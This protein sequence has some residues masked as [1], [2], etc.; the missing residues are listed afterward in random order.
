MWRELCWRYVVFPAQVGRTDAEIVFAVHM[1]PHRPPIHAAL[2]DAATGEVLDWPAA[3]GRPGLL[4]RISLPAQRPRPGESAEPASSRGPAA[5]RARP[6]ASVFAAPTG[7][8]GTTAPGSAPRSAHPAPA[9][10][11]TRRTLLQDTRAP[12]D[13]ILRTPLDDIPPLRLDDTPR[14]PDR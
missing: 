8:S 4:Q 9:P 5:G 13:D 14:T 12:L 1:R 7:P 2:V 3:T 6:P 10:P 11:S